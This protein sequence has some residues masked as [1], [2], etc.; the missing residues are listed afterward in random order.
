MNPGRVVGVAGLAQV[1]SCIAVLDRSGGPHLTRGMA[2]KPALAGPC[3]ARAS[4][5]ALRVAANHRLPVRGRAGVKA[6][7]SILQ[8]PC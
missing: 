2:C 7:P 3:A 8:L 1:C 6:G 5:T 4:A